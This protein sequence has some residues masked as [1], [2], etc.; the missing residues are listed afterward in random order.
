MRAL[1]FL[2][3]TS[4]VNLQGSLLWSLESGQVEPEE[5]ELTLD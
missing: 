4:L 5:P 1:F 3:N 2:Q